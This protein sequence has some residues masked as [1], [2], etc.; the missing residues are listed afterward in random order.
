MRKYDFDFL[1]DGQP[2]LVPDADITVGCEDLDAPESGRD[3]GG[4]MHRMVM[5]TDVL[6]IPLAYASLTRDEYRY[7]KSLFRG[8]SEFRVDCLDDDGNPV[9]FHA[10]RSK[11]GITYHNRRTGE[12]KNYNF[13]IIQ[14]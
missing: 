11:H 5:R 9:S 7:M 2:I 12:Y 4:F 8:K 1:I 10:Y 3:E 6:T 14:C 13:N